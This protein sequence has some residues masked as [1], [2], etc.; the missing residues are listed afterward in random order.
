LLREDARRLTV[1]DRPAADSLWTQL[2]RPRG[3]VLREYRELLRQWAMSEQDAP[4]AFASIMDGE[5]LVHAVAVAACA[6]AALGDASMIQMI[7]NR[8]EGTPRPAAVDEREAGETR[9]TMVAAIE[10]AVRAMNARPGDN[11][12]VIEQPPAKPDPSSG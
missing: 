12:Q 9:A 11:A 1:R 10:A 4:G 5:P 6:K 2:L 7:Y 3:A 8:I